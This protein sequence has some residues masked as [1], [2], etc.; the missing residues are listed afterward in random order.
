MVGG[1]DDV[2]CV[3][4]SQAQADMMFMYWIK[5][6]YYLHQIIFLMYRTLFPL[7]NNSLNDEASL[8]ALSVA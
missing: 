2:L 4:L 1:D 3:G 6:K 7:M 8:S 5:I